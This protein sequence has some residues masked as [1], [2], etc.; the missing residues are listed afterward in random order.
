[1]EIAAVENSGGKMEFKG[2]DEHEDEEKNVGREEE[3]GDP[4]VE[5]GMEKDDSQPEKGLLLAKM[6]IYGS[7]FYYWIMYFFYLFFR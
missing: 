4:E 5:D 7:L 2:E 6:C 3:G 1:M